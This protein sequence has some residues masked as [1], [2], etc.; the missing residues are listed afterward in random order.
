MEPQFLINMI[1]GLAI[2][3]GGWLAR[4]LWDSVQKLKDDV[5]QIEI[6]LP[7]LYIRKD[8]FRE[9]LKEIKDI[10]AEIFREI[11]ALKR[12]KVDK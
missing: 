11:N 7:A 4:Q 5:H 8:D 2:A 6:D 12:E 3:I 9:G 10:L 1:A